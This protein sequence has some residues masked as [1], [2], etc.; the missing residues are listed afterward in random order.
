MNVDYVRKRL[1]YNPET[2]IF[3]WRPRPLGVQMT[4]DGIHGMLMKSPAI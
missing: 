2:G 1:D 3:I 4:K